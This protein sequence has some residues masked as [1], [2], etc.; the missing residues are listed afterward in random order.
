MTTGTDV[1]KTITPSN[2]NLISAV[3]VYCGSGKGL[4]PA[5]TIGARKLG[6]ALADNG[7][8]LV[9]GGG[10]LGLDRKSVV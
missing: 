8:R 6:K 2:N 3:C 1:N 5:Y 7:I 4:N 9:Y 10:S